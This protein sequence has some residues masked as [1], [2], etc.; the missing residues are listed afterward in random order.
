MEIILEDVEKTLD[1]FYENGIESIIGEYKELCVTLD[2]EVLV[3]TPEGEYNAYAKD[4]TQSGELIVEK[5][6]KTSTVNSGEVSV[7][8]ILGYI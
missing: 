5:D 7:R 2:K 4:I 1:V 3:I 8:G 6:G